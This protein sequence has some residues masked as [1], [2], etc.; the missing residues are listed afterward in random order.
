MTKAVEKAFLDTFGTVQPLASP[1]TKDILSVIDSIIAAHPDPITF[2]TNDSKILE[3][4]EALKTAVRRFLSSERDF[5]TLMVLVGSLLTDDW[6]AN[7]ARTIGDT[8]A[9]REEIVTWWFAS[10]NN[11]NC[12]AALVRSLLLFSR[13]I[14]EHRTEQFR[15]AFIDFLAGHKKGMGLVLAVSVLSKDDEA[16]IEPLKDFVNQV[17]S[18]DYGDGETRKGRDEIIERLE[19]AIHKIEGKP[20]QK[21]WWKFGR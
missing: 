5:Q 12:S 15:A 13:H 14:K 4:R 3:T 19:A 10:I 9:E 20:Q 8:L 11:D 1:E 16:L 7:L 21:K 2:F 18:H 6:L 17:K